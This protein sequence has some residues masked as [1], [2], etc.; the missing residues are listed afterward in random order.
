MQNTYIFT[1]NIIFISS[2]LQHFIKLNLEFLFSPSNTLKLY[3]TKLFF[4]NLSFKYL[5][6]NSF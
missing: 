3:L 1:N 5:T 4:E 2:S 6:K